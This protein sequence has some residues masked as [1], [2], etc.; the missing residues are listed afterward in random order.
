MHTCHHLWVEGS[1]YDGDWVLC[2]FQRDEEEAEKVLHD[3]EKDFGGVT[4]GSF[5]KGRTK[6]RRKQSVFGSDQEDESEEV[7]PPAEKTGLP[8]MEVCRSSFLVLL[9]VD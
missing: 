8:K 7:C 9:S 6:V 2:V 4:H 3:F 5:G 1:R